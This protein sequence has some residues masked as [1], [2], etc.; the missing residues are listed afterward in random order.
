[1]N[2]PP[3]LLLLLLLLAS[4]LAQAESP[5]PTASYPPPNFPPP[6]GL[7]SGANSYPKFSAPVISA[8][9]AYKTEYFER[10]ICNPPAPPSETQ[11]AVGT[12]LGGVV[13]GILGNQVGRGR[14]R[15]AATVIGAVGGAVAGNA[16]STTLPSTPECRTVSE[17]Q[18]V[19]VGYDVVYDFSGQR[20]HVRLPTRPGPSI[21][22]E[23]RPE[24]L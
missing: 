18:Q 24:V 16:V 15:T 1:M 5:V 4:G 20:G 23:V 9:P 13:G 10:R 17:P 21:I 19:I 14:G 11:N 2:K 12:V 3:L 8:E 7:H 6:P 22:V